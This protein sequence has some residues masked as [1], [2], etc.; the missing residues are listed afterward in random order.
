MS[1]DHARRCLDN[2]ARA[3]SQAVLV[4]MEE[5][6]LNEVMRGPLAELFDANTF[7]RDVSGS[8][9]NWWGTTATRMFRD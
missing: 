4:D 6:V 5:G 9:N 2:L 1:A 7:V 8:G 3:A